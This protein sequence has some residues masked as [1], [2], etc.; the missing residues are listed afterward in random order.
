MLF[1]FESVLTSTTSKNYPNDF[2]WVSHFVLVLCVFAK[3]LNNCSLPPSMFPFL[4]NWFPT[5]TSSSPPSTQTDN[6]HTQNTAT[7]LLSA[8]PMDSQNK[9]HRCEHT[10]GIVFQGLAALSGPSRIVPASDPLS[11]S[12]HQTAW[13]SWRRRRC[14]ARR[15]WR[16]DRSIRNGRANCDPRRLLDTLN[17]RSGNRKA[18]WLS[19]PL[20]LLPSEEMPPLYCFSLNNCSR[21]SLMSDTIFV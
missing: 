4:F 19:A 18:C 8:A 1:C 17:C 12:M 13:C 9:R 10:D 6:T 2:S 3:N 16:V 20:H 14:V 21:C 7:C 5:T 15:C 11:Y